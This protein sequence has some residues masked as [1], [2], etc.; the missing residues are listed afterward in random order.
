MTIPELVAQLAETLKELALRHRE[1]A[2]RANRHRLDLVA[3]RMNDVLQGAN[4]LDESL[5]RM[6]PCDDRRNELS[7]ELGVALQLNV[8]DRTPSIADIRDALGPELSKPLVEAAK[9]LKAAIAQSTQLAER[10]RSLAEA[11]RRSTEATVKALARIVVRSRSTQAAYDRAGVRSTGVAVP[12]S[13][14]AWE[15]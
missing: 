3:R 7:R 10:N 13:H 4:E 14:R 11:G 12:I 6:S 15:G 2:A 9:E 8:Q 5:E 1:W